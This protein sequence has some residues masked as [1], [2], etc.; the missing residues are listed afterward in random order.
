[1]TQGYSMLMLAKLKCKTLL[2]QWGGIPSCD[3]KIIAFS[4]PEFM[5]LK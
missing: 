1:M 2:I 3:A 4:I 5:V